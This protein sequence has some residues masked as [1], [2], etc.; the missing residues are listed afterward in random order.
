[1]ETRI[2]YRIQSKNLNKEDIYTDD[3][4]TVT[5]M[6]TFARLIWFGRCS[7]TVPYHHSDGHWAP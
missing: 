1:M 5:A 4:T 6:Q 2:T 3:R 7:M